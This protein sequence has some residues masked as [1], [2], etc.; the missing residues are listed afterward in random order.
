MVA[1]VSK[2]S[3]KNGT[4]A[5]C[6]LC[7][8]PG[9]QKL[10]QVGRGPSTT[11]DGRLWPYPSVIWICGQCGVLQKNL[12]RPTRVKIDRLYAT[13]KPHYLSGGVEQV[14]FSGRRNPETRTARAFRL[15]S[16][17]LPLRGRVLDFG[18]GNGAALKSFLARFPGWT[19]DAYD[20]SSHKKREVLA[21]PRVKYF[22]SK[23]ED[24][25]KYRYDAVILWH[26]LEHIFQPTQILKTIRM[27]LKP[28]GVLVL[29]V[30]DLNRN[31]YDLGIYDHVSHFT[32]ASLLRF[33]AAIGWKAKINGTAWFHNTLT[34]AFT[35]SKRFKL[36]STE[37][38]PARPFAELQK[39]LESFAKIKKKN[40]VIFGTA[41]GALLAYAQSG[42]KASAF[43]DDDP[44]RW[45][46]TLFGV[47]ILPPRKRPSLPILF[48]FSELNAKKIRTKLERR[49]KNKNLEKN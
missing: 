19:G 2:L 17:R 49:Q 4:Q 20:V 39:Q 21:L 11:S 31:P 16:H 35:P 30:P 36:R 38:C 46:K 1:K 40:H 9:L 27:L 13:Y 47:P 41:Q 34:L 48:P 5:G 24:L 6:H 43:L 26:T 22:Y 14:V 12:D 8:A 44:N 37:R 33:M 29:Q 25:S 28:N 7:G 15:L 23:E 32:R 18:T 10:G 45:G 3:K 42:R